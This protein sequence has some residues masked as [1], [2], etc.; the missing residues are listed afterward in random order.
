M[1][2][3]N[4]M[5]RERKM[6]VFLELLGWQKG[7]NCTIQSIKSSGALTAD[8]AGEL[9]VLG[10]DGDSLGVD[11]S[12]VGVLE[13]TNKVSLGG[14]LKS[15]DGRSLESQVSLEVLGDFSDKSLEWK[16]SDQELSRLLVSSD[17]TKGD[18]TRLYLCGFLTP[19]V[20]GADFL[21]ALV[22]NCFLGALPPVDLRAVCLV[23][24]I[25]SDDSL[26][27][28]NFKLRC[29]VLKAVLSVYRHRL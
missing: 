9:H 25:S 14:L 7:L 20:A 22:A 18:G 27:L 15:Q 10:H 17:L 1:K 6:Q 21:A 12:Q 28:M 26:E 8:S 19:P 13:K 29:A 3:G 23:R 16:L 4:E 24:A 2:N 5:Y 11:G